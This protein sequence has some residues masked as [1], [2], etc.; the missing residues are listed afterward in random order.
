MNEYISL[1][2]KIAYALR[3]PSGVDFPS[4][5]NEKEFSYL[6]VTLVYI[7]SLKRE[8]TEAWCNSCEIT[9][10]QVSRS[11]GV[12]KHILLLECLI[13]CNI[14]N[15]HV[16]KFIYRY[17]FIYLLATCVICCERQGTKFHDLVISNLR[18]LAHLKFGDILYT[19]IHLMSALDRLVN[20][21]DYLNTSTHK[22]LIYNRDEFFSC[23]QRFTENGI[24]T[25][26]KNLGFW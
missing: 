23:I 10:L 6:P 5:V 16:L 7:P 11:L 9:L 8:E 13:A 22:T 19:F 4:L 25:V 18:V 2:E 24:W 20:V 26:C 14:S 21:C 17:C 15:V 12:Q 3:L 1:K